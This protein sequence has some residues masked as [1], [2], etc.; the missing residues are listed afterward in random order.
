MSTILNSDRILVMDSGKLVE[1]GTHKELI[2]KKDGY[3]R[4]LYE[5][6]FKKEE[7]TVIQSQD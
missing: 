1:S 5:I 3:Y 4:S 7:S 2:K 6:Q